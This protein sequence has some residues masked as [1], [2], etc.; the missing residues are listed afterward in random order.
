M[1]RRATMTPGELTAYRQSRNEAHKAWRDSKGEVWKQQA[2][3]KRQQRQAD[4]VARAQNGQCRGSKRCTEPQA[5]DSA[6]CLRHWF[7]TFT[8]TLWRADGVERKD[9]AEPLLS[10]IWLEQGGRCAITGVL[11]VPGRDA[12]LDHIEH[13]S[14]GGSNERS[15]LRFIHV[16]LNRLRGTMT[17]EEM[18]AVVRYLIPALT[19][20]AG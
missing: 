4:L 2:T 11:L 5:G 19:A 20:W 13:V 12:S 16:A 8:K 10:R 14:R 15:N 18:K 7:R 17:D 9:I 1:D 6:Y 3:K